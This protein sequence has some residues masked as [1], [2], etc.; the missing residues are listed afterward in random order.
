MNSIFEMNL[1]LTVSHSNVMMV[2]SLS[3]NNKVQVLQTWLLLCP[4]L[5]FYGQAKVYSTSHEFTK[6]RFI[7][8][9]LLMLYRLI[10]CLILYRVLSCCS[11]IITY[12]NQDSEIRQLGIKTICNRSG[13]QNNTYFVDNYEN[14]TQIHLYMIYH[15]LI[16]DIIHE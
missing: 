9:H 10:S 15:Y 6:L 7:L 11:N 2:S 12:H 3:E 4:S 1:V 5:F 16:H 8:S 13:P 14:I